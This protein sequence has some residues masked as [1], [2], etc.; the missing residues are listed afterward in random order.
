LNDHRHLTITGEPSMTADTTPGPDTADTPAPEAPDCAVQPPQSDP[1]TDPR[2]R[3]RPGRP[4][5]IASPRRFD[6]PQPA[7]Q[8]RSG[9]KD[10][11][12]L[13]VPAAL[14][15]LVVI[16]G[17]VLVVLLWRPLTWWQPWPL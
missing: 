16:T 11:S 12:W 1:G 14:L 13:T 2:A 3:P 17:A 7:R 8:S 5:Q 4:R 6:T 15:A 9:A 10:R